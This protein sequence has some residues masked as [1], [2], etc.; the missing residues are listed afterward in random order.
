MYNIKIFVGT[1]TTPYSTALTECSSGAYDGGFRTLSL[2][3]RAGPAVNVLTIRRESHPDANRM[4][5][6]SEVR[7]YGC[8]NLLNWSTVTISYNI[9]HTAATEVT[10]ISNLFT[11]YEHR[12]PN[13]AR[14]P[15]KDG[16]Y[17]EASYNSCY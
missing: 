6:M 7:A 10:P 13:I 2:A 1:D 8:P 14:N 16:S 12:S 15:Y 11:N 5:S 9:G 4:F 3:C 17:N